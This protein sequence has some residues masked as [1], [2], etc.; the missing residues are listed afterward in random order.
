[1]R[2][3]AVTALLFLAAIAPAAELITG[4]G[5]ASG[6]GEHVLERNDD[7]SL[8]VDLRRVFPTGLKYF[9]AV[10]TSVWVNNNGNFT[11]DTA[12]EQFT[13]DAITANSGQPI[14]AAWYADVDTRHEP[15]GSG[16][17]TW[18]GGP[19]PS[20]G[21]YYDLDAVNGIFTVTWDYVGYYDEHWDKRC[22][23]QI[24][25]I[26][27][28]TGQDF[29]IEYRYKLLQWTTGD[30]SGGSGG[31][32]GTVVRAGYSAGNGIN[33]FEL[34]QSGNQSQMLNLV[35]T[36]GN[37]G[38]PGIWSWEVHKPVVEITPAHNSFTN[39]VTIPVTFS[40]SRDATG[41]AMGDITVTGGTAGA[42]T[43][44]V[45]SGNRNLYSLPITAPE[46]TLTVSVAAAAVTSSFGDTNL[47]ASSAITVDRTVP[48][49]PAVPT[50]GSGVRPVLRGTA[51]AYATVRIR[52]GSRVIATVTADAAGNWSWQSTGLTSGSYSVTVTATDRA[53]N[54]SAASAAVPM[55][56]TAPSSDDDSDGGGGGCGG[57]LSGLL[58]AAGLALGLRRRR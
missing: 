52:V 39:D 53:G 29:D 2:R 19:P 9:G 30:A 38:K 26:R 57:G 40:V 17:R 27:V 56:Y 23:F 46:G 37:T 3:S 32:G 11:F 7:E 6:Y 12:L 47:A 24:R 14:I 1:M 45:L 44:P 22:A 34:P 20:N 25:L 54:A 13:P 10:Y 55:A 58:L 49:V 5:G 21:V 4:L 51:E 48:A 35:T 41:F 33:F 50:V 36:R 15:D 18:Y 43:G 16:G 8:L 28:G 31:L 42:L